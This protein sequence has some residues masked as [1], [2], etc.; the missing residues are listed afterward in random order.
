MEETKFLEESP[1]NDS[2]T[3]LY[4]MMIIIAALLWNTAI[5]SAGLYMYIQGRETLT[6]IVGA[7]TAVSGAII[8]LTGIWKVQQKKEETKQLEVKNVSVNK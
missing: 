5:L 6:V 2:A 3:R 7:I 1:G 4:I 8:T